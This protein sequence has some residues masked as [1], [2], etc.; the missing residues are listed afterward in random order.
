MSGALD[1]IR[2]LEP[3]A[4]M[5]AATK[6]YQQMMAP[7]ADQHVPM[8]FRTFTQHKEAERHDDQQ[9]DQDECCFGDLRGD[10]EQHKH[11]DDAPNLNRSVE[12]RASP[13]NCRQG[14]VAVALDGNQRQTSTSSSKRPRGT[15]DKARQERVPIGQATCERSN[16]YGHP[17][18]GE[19]NAGLLTEQV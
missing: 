1:A 4:A 10:A 18:H 2:D 9:G 15:D 6:R 3:Q 14:V 12:H 5:H 13:P 17:E 7:E 19:Q 8:T 11:T 16:H